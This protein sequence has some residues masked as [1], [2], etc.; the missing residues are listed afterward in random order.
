MRGGNGSGE[1]HR[2]IVMKICSVCSHRN[3]AMLR[4]CRFCG[5]PFETRELQ[6]EDHGLPK[7]GIAIAAEF[8]IPGGL[9]MASG[10]FMPFA[11]AG[12][13]ATT[14]LAKTGIPVVALLCCGA[15]VG[16]FG[17]LSLFLRRRYFEW[18]TTAAAL[19]AV[20][21]LYY[22]LMIEDQV[23]TGAAPPAGLGLGIYFCYL[24]AAFSLIAG[25]VCLIRK[26]SAYTRVRF[27]G[28]TQVLSET[29]VRMRP[30]FLQRP[31]RQPARPVVRRPAPVRRRRR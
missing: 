7:R 31:V 28:V 11:E 22:H 29:A 17:V 15:I 1:T 8:A 14:G 24:G 10:P 5:E 18:Y 16:I 20:T 3:L 19:A 26:P 23:A 6:P 25:A 9:L 27:A 4:Q 13:F 2:V 30:R 12:E 21:T